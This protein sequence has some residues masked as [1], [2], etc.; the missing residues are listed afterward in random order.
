MGIN[1]RGFFWVAWE[2]EIWLFFKV[3][4][5]GFFIFHEIIFLWC[6]MGWL[7]KKGGYIYFLFYFICD[8]VM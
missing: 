6:G 8:M 5:W 3:R 7:E 2:G 1:P 4:R